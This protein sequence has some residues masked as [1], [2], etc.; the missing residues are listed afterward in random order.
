MPMGPAGLP[1]GTDSSTSAAENRFGIGPTPEYIHLPFAKKKA[2]L[3]LK[4]TQAP[5]ESS[6]AIH[7]SGQAASI[8]TR[9]GNH[10]VD[11]A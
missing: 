5:D 10:G 1:L 4:P 6:V 9:P 2:C 7:S 3:A 11:S 8:W